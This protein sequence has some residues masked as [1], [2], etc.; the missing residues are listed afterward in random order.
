[1]EFTFTQLIAL[2][3]IPSLIS[4][5]FM[6]AIQKSANKREKKRDEQEKARCEHQLLM[7]KSINASITL[8]MATAKAVGRIPDANC[9]GDMHKALEE[10]EEAQKES[11]AFL[12][13]QVSIYVNR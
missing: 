3:G 8:G 10:A 13:K 4:G 7:M 2:L 1:M 5:V 9:N 12:N 11:N 6:L